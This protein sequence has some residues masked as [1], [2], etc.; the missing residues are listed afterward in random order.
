MFLVDIKKLLTH[1]IS[2]IIIAAGL[3]LTHS[4]FAPKTESVVQYYHATPPISPMSRMKWR[5]GHG[6]GPWV[7]WVIGQLCDGSHE[8]WITKDDPFPSLGLGTC[9][10]A[11]Y[12][13]RTAALYNLGSDS[14]LAWANDT[15][16]HYAAIH[17]PRWQTIGPAV[18]HTD[19]PQT[20]HTYFSGKN[21]VPP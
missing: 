19:I 5:N 17:C 13:T 4:S 21:V 8:S 7:M 15:V 20:Y 10:S 12:E 1:S 18:Q 9:Y 2:P 6:R 3:T 14:W 16:A 11:A